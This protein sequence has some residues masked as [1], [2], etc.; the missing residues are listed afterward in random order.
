MFGNCSVLHVIREDRADGS[1]RA[2]ERSVV[3]DMVDWTSGHLASMDLWNHR[4]PRTY[5][6]MD[7]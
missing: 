1:S 6:I 3:M 4:I 5:R 2:A 7:E